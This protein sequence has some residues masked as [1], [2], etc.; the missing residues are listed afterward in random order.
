MKNT[1]KQ[2]DKFLRRQ[3]KLGRGVYIAKTARLSAT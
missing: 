2:L 1:V 3:P